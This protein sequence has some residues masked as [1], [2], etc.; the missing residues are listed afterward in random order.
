MSACAF[1]KSSRLCTPTDYQRVFQHAQFKVSSKAI[2]ILAIPNALNQPRLGLVLAKKNIRLAV[3]RNRLKRL[4]RESF[5]LR[6]HDI[7]ALDIVVLARRGL[8]QKENSI[9]HA[10]FNTL[11]NNLLKRA[12][13]APV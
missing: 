9:I 13:T 10:E 2:L 4:I 1:S 6:Q 12:N 11:W 3:Q 8:D 5:R 7:P